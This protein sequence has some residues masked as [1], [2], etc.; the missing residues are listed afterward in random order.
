MNN[1]NPTQLTAEPLAI[2]LDTLCQ[3]IEVWRD[4]FPEETDEIIQ[5]QQDFSAKSTRLASDGLKL[6]IGIMGQVKAGKSSFLNA[7]LFD[8]QPVLPVAAT[9]KTANL[10][11]ISFG[12]T[13]KL[14]VH[15]YSPEEWQDIETSAGSQSEHAEARVARDLVGMVK[16]NGLN[17]GQ[18]LSEPHRI[19]TALD[20]DGLM[21]L[22]NDYV[23][24]NGHYTAVVKSTEIQLP[25][26]ELKGYDVVDT[27]GMNDPVPSRTQKT[28][29]YMAKCD[30]VFFLSR[31]SQFLDQSD[32]DLLA[33][34][35]PGSGVKRMVL[36]AGQ[37]DGAISDDGFN[38]A[39]LA[40]TEK[41]IST[42]LVR[43]AATEMEKL[44]AFRD[45][46]GDPTIAA[47]LRTLKTPILA[48]TF[49][50]GFSTW[51]P[52][53]WNSAMRH[54]HQELTGMAVD[55][56][57]SYS[58]TQQDWQRIGNF[59]SLRTAYQTARQDKQ[60]LLQAQRDELLPSTQREL[61]LRLEALSRAASN[62]ARH[63]KSG[64]LAKIEADLKACERSIAVIAL[65]S[66]EV[67]N[68][69]LTRIDDTLREAQVALNENADKAAEVRTREG[70]ELSTSSYEVSTSRWYNPFSWGRTE[71]R[72]RTTTVSYTYIATADVIEQLVIYAN[73]STARVEKRFNS[74]VSMEELRT[75]LKSALLTALDTSAEGFDP[76]EFRNVLERTLNKLSLPKLH[77]PQGDPASAISSR[78]SGEIRDNSQSKALQQAQHDA[79]KSIQRD[80][81]RA[82]ESAVGELRQGLEA[83][84]QALASE[85]SQDLDKERQQLITAFANKDSEL[86]TYAE[87]IEFCHSNQQILSDTS[88]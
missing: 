34:Q 61:Q 74:V 76:T 14:S 12:E 2:K 51:A 50:H 25:L 80:V 3:R 43:R 32:M 78:F 23:G 24:E 36:V 19:V 5:L 44:A 40:E 42:R 7:L 21:H 85:F 52:D 68:A 39:S 87:I 37:L 57:N 31:A 66:S 29:E 60:K 28:R 15:F 35:L 16:K 6:S 73:D 72:Y 75:D 8:G 46:G 1:S 77:I 62:R 54:A 45:E 4:R 88:V 63:L 71:R 55:S 38:R 30:V 17:V 58:F 41:N 69:V 65:R 86:S 11:R 18:L 56:W 83:A 79:I 81:L 33:R 59:S 84:N 64:D 47:M 26:D 13:P 70:T 53:S 22:L 67:I 10:T 48:S 49:A 9:P 27:P 82:L 20:V